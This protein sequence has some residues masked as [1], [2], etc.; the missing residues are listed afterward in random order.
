MARLRITA[1]AA[2]AL[3]VGSATVSL[4][5][6]AGAQS[7]EPGKAGACYT[8]RPSRQGRF[9]GIIGPDSPA[10]ERGS[11]CPDGA[12]PQSP[13]SKS[14]ARGYNG[15]PPMSDHGGPVMNTAGDPGV[16]TV[17]PIYWD[18][19]ASM[20]SGYKA[21][22]NQFINDVAADSGALANVYSVELQYGV[23]YSVTAGSPITDVDPFP[24]NGCTP[25]SGPVY[26]DDSGYS[27]CL[28]DAQLQSEIQNV[29]SANSLPSDLGHLYLLFLPKGVESC[30]T[31]ADGA[32][33]GSC[34]VNPD[35]NATSFCGYHSNL[36]GSLIYADEPFPIYDS[37]LGYTCSSQYGPGNESPNGELDADVEMY[38]ESHETMES[39]T[40]P[41]GTAW[42][43]RADNEIADDCAFIYGSPIGGS[44]GAEYNQTINGDHYFIQEEFSNQNYLASKKTACVQ[45][46]DLPSALSVKVPAIGHAGIPVKLKVKKPLGVT[47]FSWNFGDL[48][49]PGTTASVSHIYSSPGTYT[50]VLTLTDVIGFQDTTTT[51]SGTITV[52]SQ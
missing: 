11:L 34:T 46:I 8:P 49:A 22:T 39:V 1:V 17:T 12:D 48:S 21:V 28:T 50:V 52:R 10:A 30:F 3:L 29:V 20:S 9:L 36:G 18:P 31:S 19:A 27:S 6:A 47:A 24:S 15:D 25:D 13:V 14:A 4:G 16:V 43:D 37:P 26:S 51:L 7:K 2:I 41:L 42:Y 45:R 35:Y 40:D 23:H 38:P 32:H 33:R 44:P 5:N